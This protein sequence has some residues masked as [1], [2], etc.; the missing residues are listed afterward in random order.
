MARGG[1][2]REWVGGLVREDKVWG[3][4]YRLPGGKRRVVAGNGMQA[5][6]PPDSVAREGLELGQLPYHGGAQLHEHPRRLARRVRHHQ[7]RAPCMRQQHSVY[8]HSARGASQ[9]PPLTQVTGPF[10]HDKMREGLR[11]R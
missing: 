4:S 7:W 11:A 8:L 9:W 1:G 5:G 3:G 10:G 6:A 2:G